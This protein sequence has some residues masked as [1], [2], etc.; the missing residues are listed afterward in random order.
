MKRK[1]SL[2]EPKSLLEPCTK[3][4]RQSDS[5]IP[6]QKARV[7]I[8]DTSFNIYEDHI[9]SIEAIRDFIPNMS[10]CPL[11]VEYCIFSK[12]NTKIYMCYSTHR[13]KPVNYVATRI[14]L[15]LELF[16]PPIKLCGTDDA[17]TGIVMFYCTRNDQLVS[18]NEKQLQM[19]WCLFFKLHC[20]YYEYYTSRSRV[21][22]YK[23]IIIHFLHQRPRNMISQRMKATT[24]L[25]GAS[26][27]RY[28]IQTKLAQRVHWD[29]FNDIRQYKVYR[30]V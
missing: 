28:Y 10:M 26:L 25:F 23:D 20:A 17:A 3:H 2:Q 27:M 15:D 6:P 7:F 29:R 16:D 19:T 8:L 13:E 5:S 11:D 24:V 14:L 18:M 4:R 9:N 12:N 1:F 22:R 30:K 21:E